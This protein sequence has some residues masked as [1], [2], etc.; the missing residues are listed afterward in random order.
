MYGGGFNIRWDGTATG[1]FYISVFKR[2]YDLLM[3]AD[4]MFV[5]GCLK[6]LSSF[7]E[8]LGCFL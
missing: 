4:L 3:F 5:S 1:N 2:Y 6:M 7:L 8:D